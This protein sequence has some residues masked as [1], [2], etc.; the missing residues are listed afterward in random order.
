MKILALEPY[1]GGS[2]KA[3]LEDWRTHS[4]HE[5]TI[6]GL[7]A[8]KWKWRMRHAAVTLAD[9]VRKELAAGRRWERLLCS[10]MLNLAEF[11]GLASDRRR[12]SRRP[13]RRSRFAACRV[14]RT[15]TRISSRIRSAIGASAT[16][17]SGLST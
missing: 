13:F 17:T 5:W 1:H 12:G 7:P 2:H 8:R 11:L 9:R 14:S 10:D 6:L 15:S 16:C 4:R 3:F